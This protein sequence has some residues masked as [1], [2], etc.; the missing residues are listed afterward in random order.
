MLKIFDQLGRRISLCLGD[1]F[2][3]LGDLVAIDG[4]L[5]DATLS[6]TWADYSTSANKVKV[7]IIK[8]SLEIDVALPQRLWRRASS[9][10]TQPRIR[11]NYLNIA[12][13]KS[14]TF[15]LSIW[16]ILPK[17]V[18]WAAVSRGN[19]FAF[20]AHES[21]LLVVTVVKSSPFCIPSRT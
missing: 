17:I 1:S 4:S 13:Y 19:T 14:S 10:Q 9:S 18:T 7:H 8:T 11:L 3:Q 20:F 6:M 5:I 12:W 2:L 16:L 15:C 21:R